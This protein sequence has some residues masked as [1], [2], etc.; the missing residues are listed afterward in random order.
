MQDRDILKLILLQEF[1]RMQAEPSTFEDDP[2]Q[3]ILNKYAGLK[4]I[5][6]YLMTPSFEDYVTGIYV[7]AP[8]PTT[9]KICLLYTSD[10][11]DD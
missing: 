2:M 6:T 8:K 7:V 3:F 1:D 9:F 11:A 5:L 10:A 4:N